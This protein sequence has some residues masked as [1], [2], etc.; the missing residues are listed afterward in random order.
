MSKMKNTLAVINGQLDIEEKIS[1]LEDRAIDTIQNETEC[2]FFLK[3]KEH[4]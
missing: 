4:W 3:W 1:E 2:S